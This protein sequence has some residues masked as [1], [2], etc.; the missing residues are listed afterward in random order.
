MENI[1]IQQLI[2]HFSQLVEKY[3]KSNENAV[4]CDIKKIYKN[5]FKKTGLMFV[6]GNVH[7]KGFTFK[8]IYIIN[9]GPMGG[10]SGL[11]CRFS[12]DQTPEELEYSFYDI[13]NIID[14]QNFKSYSFPYI[15]SE[16][17]MSEAFNIYVTGF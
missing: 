6:S 14:P 4:Y 5:E 12:F 7:F 2:S 15:F 1:L 9:G 16:R 17:E 11:E 8:C 13:L 3:A 10:K